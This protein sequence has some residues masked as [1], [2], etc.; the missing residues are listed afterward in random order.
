MRVCFEVS[1]TD[2]CGQSCAFGM[3]IS[4]GE[5]DRTIEYEMLA[6]AINIE[7]LISVACLDSLGVTKENVKVITPEEYDRLYGEDGE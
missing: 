4:F 3:Q 7:N 5:T 2:D 6:K 1:T